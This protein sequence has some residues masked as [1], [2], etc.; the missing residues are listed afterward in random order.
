MKEIKRSAVYI[1]LILIFLLLL[2]ILIFLPSPSEKEKTTSSDIATVSPSKET[3][4]GSEQNL[5]REKKEIEVTGEIYIIID[6]VG[7][8]LYQLQPF[9]QLPFPISFSVLPGLAYTRE[10]VELIVHHNQEPMLHLPM[11]PLNGE[12]P[13]PGAIYSDM[14]KD[15]I[16]ALVRKHLT[17]LPEV[18]AVNNH[19]GSLITTKADT[20]EIILTELSDR[21]ILFIDSLTTANSV[22][23]DV[24]REIGITY[25]AR[26]V[27]LDNIEDPVEI[28]KAFMKGKEIAKQKGRVVLI[29]HV[30]S[31]N[32]AAVLMEMYTSSRSEGFLFKHISNLMESENT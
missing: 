7:Y 31:E 32:L 13:G 9:L 29:G 17:E 12:N 26:E 6:D 11:E 8:N 22:V 25:Y 15:E 19:M 24:A 10:T 16:I 27:F 4:A 21:G 20:M 14:K 28:K 3:K 23:A 18:Q 2:F 30:W 5:I 1:L